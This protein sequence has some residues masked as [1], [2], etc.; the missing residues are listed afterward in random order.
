MSDFR[1]YFYLA[2]P[3]DY[4]REMVEEGAGWM[5]GLMDL[6]MEEGLHGWLVGWMMDGRT[7]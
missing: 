2:R 4:D 3:T 5:D 6:W 1:E 7:N